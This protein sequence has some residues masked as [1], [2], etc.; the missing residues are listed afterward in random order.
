M[1]QGISRSPTPQATHLPLGIAHLDTHPL[2]KEEPRPM[3]K[4]LNRYLGFIQN[5]TGGVAA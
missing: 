5:N 2:R 4:V 1:P 3:E